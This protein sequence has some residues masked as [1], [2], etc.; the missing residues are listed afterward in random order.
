[1]SE[2]TLRKYVS[3]GL[4]PFGHLSQIESHATSVGFPDTNF[5]IGGVEG[6]IELKYWSAK[7]GYVLRKNQIAW[8]RDR[9]KAGGL[10]FL[11]FLREQDGKH[12]F[13]IKLDK[14]SLAAVSSSSKAADWETQA[15]ESWNGR[16]DFK[17]LKEALTNER[18]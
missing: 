17:H 2:K 8:M 14:F 1:M 3:Q 10:V 15:C 9:L 12:Y 7:K 16:M 5:C 6:G 4:K 11:L 18:N 13:L